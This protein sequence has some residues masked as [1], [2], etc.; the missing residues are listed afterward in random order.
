MFL[1]IAEY[2]Q[3]EVPLRCQTIAALAQ[4]FV[5]SLHEL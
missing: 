3:D 2:L 1:L 5:A 4:R